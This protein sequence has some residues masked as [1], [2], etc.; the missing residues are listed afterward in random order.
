MKLDIPYDDDQRDQLRRALGR[1]DD[2]D[3]IATIIAKAGAREALALATGE[4][5]FSSITD[6]R[7][8][9]VFC[10]LAEGMT[11]AEAEELIARVFKVPPASAKR[12]VGTAVARYVVELQASL[13][14]ALR[15]MLDAA[16][17]NSEVE[18]WEVRMPATFL[19]DRTFDILSRTDLPDPESASR[20]ALWRLPDETYSHLREAVA[21][22]VKSHS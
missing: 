22:P 13:D 7:S 11:L 21:L 14:T 8:F 16:E 10:L 6:L 18:R 20:G 15:A 12:M 2:K 17:W 19:R 4:G 3:Q 1:V 5:V 9:R